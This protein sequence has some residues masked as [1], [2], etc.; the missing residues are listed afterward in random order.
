MDSNATAIS[1]IQFIK[2]LAWAANNVF[3]IRLSEVKCC[4]EKCRR[5]RRHRPAGNWSCGTTNTRYWFVNVWGSRMFSYARHSHEQCK[6][7][8]GFD[9]WT[10][11]AALPS[12]WNRN[13]SGSRRFFF[14]GRRNGLSL[15]IF[16][17]F[18][19]ELCSG[20]KGTF[21]TSFKNVCIIL[22]A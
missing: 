13:T 15:G 17:W 22:E 20:D 2:P 11:V 16:R 10:I 8:P 6:N 7:V 18:K 4:C 19:E 12:A 1:R 5:T 9:L 3:P 14:F 21:W